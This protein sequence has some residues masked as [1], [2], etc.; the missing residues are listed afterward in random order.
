MTNKNVDL[1]R[2][3]ITSLD[4]CFEVEPGKTREDYYGKH[5]ATVSF[6]DKRVIA[7]NE[8]P[9]KLIKNKEVYERIQRRDPPV[10]FYYPYPGEFLSSP[11]R[12]L[13]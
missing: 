4:D 5:I 10:I 12:L 6:Q 7:V 3:I 13:N 2:A 9:Y 1:S 11:S 8:D